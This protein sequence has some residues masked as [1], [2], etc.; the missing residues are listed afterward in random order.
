MLTEPLAASSPRHLQAWSTRHWVCLRTM[1]GRHEDTCWPA[2]LALS[3]DG[4][5]L[6]S[7]STGPFGGS[8]IKVGGWACRGGSSSGCRW[9]SDREGWR[10][11]ET[12]LKRMPTHPPRP[13]PPPQVFQAAGGGG[14][15]EAGACLASLAQL[16]YH[17]KGGLCCLAF[18]PDGSSL[19]SGASD[20]TVAAWRLRWRE[21]APAAGL[22]RG[23]L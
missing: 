4:G 14:G 19:Y 20:G 23:W 17:Q 18:S 16:G 5:L 21:A 22:R 9:Q 7:G 1:H 8:T 11:A 10:A 12:T 15:H 2:C 3:P 13:A 6:A